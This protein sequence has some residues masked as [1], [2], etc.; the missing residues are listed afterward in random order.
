V[1]ENATSHD[2]QMATSQ[3]KPLS[4]AQTGAEPNKTRTFSANTSIT[5]TNSSAY[6]Q[7]SR[8]HTIPACQY[9][10]CKPH[11]NNGLQAKAKKRNCAN[12]PAAPTPGRFLQSA[13]GG[14]ATQ[15]MRASRERLPHPRWLILSSLTITPLPSSPYA[16]TPCLTILESRTFLKSMGGV[17]ALFRPAARYFGR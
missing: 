12:P 5:T 7:K 17:G 10:R 11:I 3:S 9:G 1:E 15:L 16:D 13:W 6:E 8:C 2:L 14:K 4:I